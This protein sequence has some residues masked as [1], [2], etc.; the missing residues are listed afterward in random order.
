LG[1]VKAI[2]VDA[3]IIAATNKELEVETRQGN[4]RQD[5]FYRLNVVCVKL[6]PLRERKEDI[7][8]LVE[9]FINKFNQE[10]KRKIVHID[11]EAMQA[12]INY[13]WPGNVRELENVM[14]RAI[15]LEK[16]DT[17]TKD[18]LPEAFKEVKE[19]ITFDHSLNTRGPLS[20]MTENITAEVEKKV[21]MEY[22]AKCKGN[23]KAVAEALGISRKGLYNKLKKYKLS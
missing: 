20:E 21:I 15:A 22:L 12:L 3:R 16:T 14:Q 19:T 7:P 18:S 1:G 13:S 5:L 6:A 11:I 10:Y 23:K 2:K 8:I 17:L 9:H 4:F